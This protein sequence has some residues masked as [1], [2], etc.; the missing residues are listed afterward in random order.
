MDV[1]KQK[2]TFAVIRT[3][4]KSGCECVVFGQR[5]SIFDTEGSAV[6]CST[7]KRGY[8]PVV[9]QLKCETA[10]T[11]RVKSW[12]KL[13]VLNLDKISRYFKNR[14]NLCFICRTDE[15]PSTAGA[16]Y[17]EIISLLQSIS[18]EDLAS[19]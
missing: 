8:F 14:M 13:T 9:N 12:A 18:P 10:E 16:L 4:R 17:H 3:M 5:V 2:F 1:D 15:I 19:L 11:L 6:S 7:S